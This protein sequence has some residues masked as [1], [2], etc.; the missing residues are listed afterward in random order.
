MRITSPSVAANEGLSENLFV[1]KLIYISFFKQKKVE[2]EAF[3]VV[4]IWTTFPDIL[5]NLCRLSFQHCAAVQ[6]SL[7]AAIMTSFPIVAHQPSLE[8]NATFNWVNH[9]RLNVDPMTRLTINFSNFPRH[10]LSYRDAGNF[11]NFNFISCRAFTT[12]TRRD[13]LDVEHFGWT[14]KKKL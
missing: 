11:R 13:E 5:V 2:A 3:S 6:A 8:L 9:A 10:Q 7:I 14:R 4:N 1:P 12:I